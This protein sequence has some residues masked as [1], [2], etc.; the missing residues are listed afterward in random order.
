MEE[1][2][3]NLGKYNDTSQNLHRQDEVVFSRIRIGYTRLKEA[4]RLDNSPQPQ[5]QTS[6]SVPHIQYE[7]SEYQHQITQHE[8]D[9]GILEENEEKALHLIPDT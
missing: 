4:Y 3:P 9:Q 7:C 1:I 2:K 8:I 5:C 6:I